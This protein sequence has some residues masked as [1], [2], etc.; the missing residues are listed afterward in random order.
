[1]TTQSNNFCLLWVKTAALALP[2]NKCCPEAEVNK[3]GEELIL[4]QNTSKLSVQEA[5]N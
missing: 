1:M 4:L 3:Q 5:Y 2:G